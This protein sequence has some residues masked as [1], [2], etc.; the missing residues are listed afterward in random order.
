LI[1][2]VSSKKGEPQALFL[3]HSNQKLLSNLPS[4]CFDAPGQCADA[5]TGEEGGARPK[6]T[7]LIAKPQFDN[8]IFPALVFLCSNATTCPTNFLPGCS[9]E[10]AR[11]K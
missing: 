5:F 4:I 10:A 9:M 3:H 8:P 11:W 7:S 1:P 6:Q 2:F